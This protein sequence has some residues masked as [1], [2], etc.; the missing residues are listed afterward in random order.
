[1]PDAYSFDI[2][3]GRY[4]NSC[5]PALAD[6]HWEGSPSPRATW[7]PNACYLHPYTRKEAT[8][9]LANSRVVF[10]GDSTARDV[11]NS[12]REKIGADI[13]QPD[14]HSDVFV[15]TKE[16]I[17]MQFYWDP[18]WNRTD[19]LSK[20]QHYGG[21][22]EGGYEHVN[23]LMV[24][25]AGHWFIKHMGES[26]YG[27][28]GHA[29]DGILDMVASRG[30]ESGAIAD[31][32]V[33]RPVNPVIPA[34][35]ISTRRAISRSKV[36][37]Y[38]AYLRKVIGQPR[39]V[40][41]I[42]VPEYVEA[43]YT[44]AAQHTSD[45][46]HYDQRVLLSEVEMYLNRRCNP[47]LFGKSPA[48]KATC[49]VR[50]ASIGWRQWATVLGLG[51][52]G[53]L[54]WAWRSFGS[55]SQG[56]RSRL[57]RLMVM[58]LPSV[59]LSKD[60]TILALGLL[61]MLIVDRT[62]YLPKINK[63]FSVPTFTFLTL[64]YLVPG[65]ISLTPRKDTTF[66]SRYQ[67]DEWK[68]W[69]QLAILIYHYTGAS[70]QPVIYAFI[71][72]CVA[73]Y[74]FM[75]G[76]G[77]F[78]YFYTKAEFGIKRVVNVIVRLNLLSALMAYTMDKDVLFYYFGPMVS[79]WFGVVYLTMRI[80]R[81][82]NNRPGFVLGKICASGVLC[83]ILIQEWFFQ[84]FFSVLGAATGVEWDAR[85]SVFRL[86]LD[87]WIVFVGMGVGLCVCYLK[88]GAVDVA[89]Y[90]T[91]AIWISVAA[92]VVY[93]LFV[94]FLQSKFVYNSYHPYVSPIPVVAYTILRNSPILASRTS[95]FFEWIGKF[96]LEL[97]LVQYHVWLGVDTKGLVGLG[98]G[99]KWTGFLVLGLVFFGMAYTLEGISGRL[100]K[101]LAAGDW[102]TAVGRTA[103]A[104]GVMILMNRAWWFA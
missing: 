41:D 21:R 88:S 29:L 104:M 85:E 96:S 30:H 51:F 6:G 75:T 4:Q 35:L 81:A 55:A 100:V 86:A 71:R 73:G 43:L 34:K 46:L 2:A 80:G 19:V 72:C 45:G 32:V 61:Y 48:G 33:V 1:M 95:A 60:V 10:A 92:L 99:G 22:T 93:T 13:E 54:G 50:Y 20:E 47:I 52:V 57:K 62:A 39:V 79:V 91:H 70:S 53:C 42:H 63:Y 24:F 82:W 9:C 15:K 56:D 87:R 17:E 5:D 67:T 97:F 14:K 27:Q 8:T 77:H 65:F 38:N 31:M 58:G 40:E 64:L 49:C 90:R 3:V 98:W 74:L 44:A 18:F 36:D 68:G 7:L 84:P 26:G 66:L 69:M 28:F 103:L 78:I 89:R 102:S 23:A 83:A 76:Y 59:D 11:F 16:N 94:T 12:L 37:A 25:S 101:A